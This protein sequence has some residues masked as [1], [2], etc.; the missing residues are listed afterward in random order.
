MANYITGDWYLASVATQVRMNTINVR[1]SAN[2][3]NATY[4]DSLIRNELYVNIILVKSSNQCFSD[5]YCV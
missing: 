1:P 2:V 3:E 5:I 4:L